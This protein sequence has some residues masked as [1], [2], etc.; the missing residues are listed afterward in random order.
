MITKESSTNSD[1]RLRR[2]DNYILYPPTLSKNYSHSYSLTNID[3]WR[4]IDQKRNPSESLTS[5]SQQKV[6]FNQERS[7]SI[8][9]QKVNKEKPA[10]KPGA[11]KL[12]N[13][14][15]KLANE[16]EDKATISESG[17]VSGHL[18]LGIKKK[19]STCMMNEGTVFRRL[20][21]HRTNHSVAL[22]EDLH[23][24]IHELPYWK[25][26]IELQGNFRPVM[27]ECSRE[28]LDTMVPEA[29]FL[30]PKKK[31]RKE[32]EGNSFSILSKGN[33]STK[34]NQIQLESYWSK[35]E[36]N[37]SKKKVKAKE[38]LGSTAQIKADIVRGHLNK[39]FDVASTLLINLTEV[40]K[41]CENVNLNQA[42]YIMKM[43]E[44]LDKLM[45][46]GM[47]MESPLK[48]IFLD[49][50]GY[51]FPV[52][53]IKSSDLIKSLITYEEDTE[54]KKSKRIFSKAFQDNI[55]S[56]NAETISLWKNQPKFNVQHHST[57]NTQKRVSFNFQELF[58]SV[59]T[60]EL[61]KNMNDK[62]YVEKVMKGA[63]FI[64]FNTDLL[65][66][67]TLFSQNMARFIRNVGEKEHLAYLE[68]LKNSLNSIGEIKR[69]F[70]NRH[71]NYKLIG[72]IDMM[73]DD[74][75][76]KFIYD[77]EVKKARRNVTVSLEEIQKSGVQIKVN[78]QMLQGNL[79]SLQFLKKTC[80]EVSTFSNRRSSKI[81][82]K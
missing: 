47:P 23:P 66:M 76:T 18:L 73:A 41:I 81:H 62:N 44:V 80:N 78:E 12:P 4:N 58:G 15:I 64:K 29:K 46:E 2:C 25:T 60:K 21:H 40:Y 30:T 37:I 72:K 74:L 24:S 20:P 6:D 14:R 67:F 71:Y 38:D 13:L 45:E 19:N 3:P 61:S 50:K 65:H 7:S 26:E 34:R 27:M 48:K 35:N 31:S 36:E 63:H 33:S 56:K 42:Q 11:Q 28:R 54:L 51:P 53:T 16:L 1:S 68:R 39:A 49:K 77:K 59:L 22:K 82:N 32:N 70:L 43:K 79:Q 57:L 69:D 17:L 5:R 10:K 9:V 55:K 8:G 52:N 75:V